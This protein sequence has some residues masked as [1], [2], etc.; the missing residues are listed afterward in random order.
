MKERIMHTFKN[1]QPPL[2]SFFD[3]VEASDGV[4]MPASM[5]S[6]SPMT[7]VHMDVP[8]QIIQ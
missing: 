7:S 2:V 3:V 5:S 4:E 6:K 1:D 8:K